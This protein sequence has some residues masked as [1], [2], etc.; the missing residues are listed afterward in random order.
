MRASMQSPAAVIT[1]HRSY[2]E[3]RCV[4][5]GYTLAEVMP[6]VS[7]RDGDIFS[8]DI[9][10]PSY[11]MVTRVPP[12]AA[13][14]PSTAPGT[15][16]K[17]LLAGWPFFIASSPDCACNARAAEMDRQEQETPG[18]CEANI[19]TITGWLREQATARGLPF[20]DAAGKMLI[21]RAIKQARK[22]AVDQT[23]LLDDTKTHG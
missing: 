14:P 5:R 20:I 2:L 4:E 3:A 1:C 6:C 16:L 9:T 11:P 22:N 19:D 21:R 23:R 12:F 8:I 7:S 18:W 13:Q 10:H 17:R 15:E